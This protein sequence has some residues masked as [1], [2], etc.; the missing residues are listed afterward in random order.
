[1]KAKLFVR[2]VVMGFA[3][4]CTSVFADC[5][6]V[7]VPQVEG[8]PLSPYVS[9]CATVDGNGNPLSA[10]YYFFEFGTT[11]W[12]AIQF[13]TLTREPFSGI[14]NVCDSSGCDST[15]TWAIGNEPID[16]STNGGALIEDPLERLLNQLY[17]CT[18]APQFNPETGYSCGGGLF[19]ASK[20]PP[21]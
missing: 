11:N 2:S 18:G 3:L 20:Q 19:G 5:E 14:W 7:Y 4:L 10:T 17:G 21:K 13:T 15:G 6:N 9:F 16:P 12:F 1:M 8:T